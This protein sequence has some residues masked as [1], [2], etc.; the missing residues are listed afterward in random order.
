[1]I[2]ALRDEVRSLDLD[3]SGRQ[4]LREIHNRAVAAIRDNLAPELRAELDDFSL[5]LGDMPSIGEL[6]VAHAQLAGWLEGLFRGLQ[7]AL[8]SQ[9]AAAQRQPQRSLAGPNEQGQYL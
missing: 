7:L 3:E 2:Q 8:V 5:P 6:R 1:M 9:Q 4:R